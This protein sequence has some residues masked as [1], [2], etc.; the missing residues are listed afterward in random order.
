[1]GYVFFFAHGI[2]VGI[3]VVLEH[4]RMGREGRDVRE[5][6]TLVSFGARRVVGE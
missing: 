5:W 6:L 1:M 3:G 2:G 4:G